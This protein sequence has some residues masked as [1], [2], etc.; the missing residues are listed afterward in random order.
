MLLEAFLDGKSIHIEQML[1][2][3]MHGE[4]LGRIKLVLEGMVKELKEVIRK[5]WASPIGR[6]IE[7]FLKN[8]EKIKNRILKGSFEFAVSHVK[9][10][11]LWGIECSN[12]I[13]SAV[14]IST[15]EQIQDIL[16]RLSTDGQ[17]N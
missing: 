9:S 3:D 7:V 12:Y 17:Q 11:L 8:S 14:D 10:V 2:T 13:S 16:E 1:T 6:P 4:M 5:D 15:A